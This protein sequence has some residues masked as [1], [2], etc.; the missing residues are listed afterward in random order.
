STLLP[1]KMKA[2]EFIPKS[3]VRQL[4]KVTKSQIRKIDHPHA[5][6]NQLGRIS[7]VVCGVQIK[8]EVA[9][10]AHVMSKS[11]KQNETRVPPAPLK[12]TVPLSSAS[13][14]STLELKIPRT[15]D[16]MASNP[17]E[18]SSQTVENANPP[19]IKS[20][21]QVVITGEKNPAEKTRDSVSSSKLPEG[22]FDDK[23]KDAKMRN[24]PFKDKLTEEVELFQKEMVSLEKQAGI[25]PTSR[26]SEVDRSRPD[27]AD[28]R[29]NLIFN[30]FAVTIQQAGI[31]PTSRVSEV[32][33][34]RPDLADLRN[35]LIFNEFAVTIQ[36]QPLYDKYTVL[37]ADNDDDDDERLTLAISP[38]GKRPPFD[39]QL[40]G[41][42]YVSDGRCSSAA[43]G[44][45]IHTNRSPVVVLMTD[46]VDHLE[47]EL[48]RVVF[49]R[50]EPNFQLSVEQQ[51]T[52]QFVK[53]KCCFL[54]CFTEDEPVECA[55]TCR[56]T[57]DCVQVSGDSSQSFVKILK[58]NLIK[59]SAQGFKKYDIFFSPIGIWPFPVKFRNKT[60]LTSVIFVDNRRK[61][62]PVDEQSERIIEKE[63]KEMVSGRELDEIDTQLSRHFNQT[64]A[65]DEEMEIPCLNHN[66]LQLYYATLM[67]LLKMR[68]EFV[69][70]YLLQKVGFS[71]FIYSGDGLETAVRC[72]HTYTQ[73]NECCLLIRIHSGSN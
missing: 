10:N 16:T 51:T 71:V 37:T 66:Q 20:S 44:Y 22:F 40:V 28:L 65:Y 13:S 17:V 36:L 49:D 7:C 73:M 60:L 27:L 35:N 4:I 61:F 25:T 58:V 5:R 68:Q 12:R 55:L 8:S 11:H 15:T 32:D 19:A 14:C 29:N 54:R 52:Y 24:V 39:T 38:I 59:R 48:F 30:E 31:T 21:V 26:V 6:Y 53:D 62:R 70:Y 33:R 69:R 45:Q 57:G 23:Y 3:D 34:S 63:M 56:Y 18:G 67:F 43:V 9:W 42:R 50:T 72:L 1:F 47:T 46:F 41:F 64:S 2:S